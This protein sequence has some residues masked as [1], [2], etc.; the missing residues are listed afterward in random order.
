MIDYT[1]KIT[2]RIITGTELSNTTVEDVLSFIEA[3]I[4]EEVAELV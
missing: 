4:A 1:L 3:N 2:I